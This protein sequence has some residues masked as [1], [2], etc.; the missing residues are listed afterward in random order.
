M[1]TVLL[2]TCTIVVGDFH[3]T[4]ASGSMLD[5]PERLLND[6]YLV[7]LVGVRTGD[8]LGLEPGGQLGIELR[9][10]TR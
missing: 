4:T 10:S 2:S 3:Q 5:G 9:T 7:S 8:A 6:E 1:Q